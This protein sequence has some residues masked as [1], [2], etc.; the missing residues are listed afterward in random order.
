VLTVE[1]VP[2]T[3]FKALM[4]S[5]DTPHTPTISD[6][7]ALRRRYLQRRDAAAAAALGTAGDLA[8]RNLLRGIELSDGAVVSAYWP[9][10]SELDPRPTMLELAKRGHACA[11]PVIV[12]RDAA[13]EFRAWRSG[14]TLI[15]GPFGTTEPLPTAPQVIPDVVIVPL[16][17]FDER[18]HRLGYGGGYYDRTL[19]G[20][21][22]RATVLAVGFGYADQE[23][24]ALPVD[25]FDQRLDWIVTEKE[26]RAFI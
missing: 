20:L 21:R 15:D 22:Q 9:M 23:V 25:A 16:A 19:A 13:L 8:M 1:V 12:A 6:K 14:D 26:T 11:L 5:T 2:S 18:G 24:E 4:T 10:R 3:L 7:A 17:A